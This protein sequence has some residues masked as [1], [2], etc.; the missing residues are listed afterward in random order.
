MKQRIAELV[1][2]IFGFRKFLILLALY[3]ISIIFRVK[4]L[5]SGDE[6]VRL[7][8]PTTIAFLGANGVEH[9]VSAVKDH[10]SA[11]LAAETGDDPNTVYEDLVAKSS[12]EADDAKAEAEQAGSQ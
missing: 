4:G 11:K 12:Q 7:I 1:N 6:L 9:I 10:Y 5:I 3:L 8:E 2:I